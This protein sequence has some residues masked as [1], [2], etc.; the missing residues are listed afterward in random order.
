MDD[1]LNRIDYVMGRVRTHPEYSTHV[2]RNFTN[3]LISEADRHSLTL[4]RVGIKNGM[5]KPTK[6]RDR[7]YKSLEDARGYL[8]RE[9]ISVVSLSRLGHL[10]QPLNE[11]DDSETPDGYRVGDVK[12]GSFFGVEAPKIHSEIDNLT[13][14]INHTSSGL[15]PVVK[16]FMTHLDFVRIHP[17]IDGNGR[18]ARILQDLVLKRNDLPPAV[19][20]ENERDHYLSIINNSD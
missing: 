16:A 4:E 6:G 8:T 3:S 5:K 9:G 1:T 11:E 10:I 15:H 20:P 18:A 7:C 14:F 2:R 12:F 19:I 17:Y 13:Y